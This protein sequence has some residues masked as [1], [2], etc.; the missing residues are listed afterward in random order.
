MHLDTS[1]GR[2][3]KE[4]PWRVN[5]CALRLAW[6]ASRRQDKRVSLS[7]LTNCLALVP[8]LSRHDPGLALKCS[9][10]CYGA[11]VLWA[12]DCLAL[13]L[14]LAPDPAAA[15][16]MQARPSFANLGKVP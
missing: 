5:P 13:V 15:K 3:L 14:R 8:R 7:S 6:R 4:S 2:T 16:R 11:L 12:Q 10:S 1:T 9:L